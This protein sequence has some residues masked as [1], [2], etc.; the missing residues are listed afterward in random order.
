MIL[1]AQPRHERLVAPHDH[2]DKQIRD[3]HHVDQSQHQQHDL[4]FAKAIGMRHQVPQLFQEEHD[5]DALRNDQAQVQRQLQPAGTEDQI[6]QHAQAGRGIFN[7]VGCEPY[8]G[9]Q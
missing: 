4:H 3:H 7:H 2:H 5:V 1:Q 9:V 6:G 8:V